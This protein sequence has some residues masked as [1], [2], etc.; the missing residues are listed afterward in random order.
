MHQWRQFL[1]TLLFASLVLYV[2]ACLYGFENILNGDN[3]VCI[4]WDFLMTHFAS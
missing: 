3:I 2:L 4:I 1:H